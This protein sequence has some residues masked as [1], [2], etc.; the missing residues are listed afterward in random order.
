SVV[1]TRD[2]TA[3]TIDL[4]APE[5]ITRLQS[6]QAV[7]TVTDAGGVAQVVFAFNGAA[8]GTLTAAPFTVP[9]AVPTGVAIGD[10]FVVSATATDRAG[11]VTTVTRGVRV[12]ADGAIVGQVLSDATG[13]A[14]AN[15]A[16]H[17]GSDT[18]TTDAQGRY[19]LPTDQT[20]V[21][22]Q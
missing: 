8:A 9:L 18:R 13:L 6:G 19:T 15:A 1:V 12:A 17:I 16:V 10:T 2:S 20:Q 21:A 4:A 22:L 11:N 7:A 5:R 14:I 3:P